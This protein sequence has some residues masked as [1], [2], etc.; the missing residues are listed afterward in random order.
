MIYPFSLSEV[1][2]GLGL[3]CVIVHALVLWKFDKCKGWCLRAHKNFRLGLVVFILAA[4][5]VV[6]LL[7]VMDLMEYSNLRI[8][9]IG[10]VVALAAL[11]VKHLPDYLAVRGL[12]LILVLLAKVLLD[13]AFLRDEPSKF[14]ITALAYLFA[15]AGM[16][17]LA[18]PY[19]FRDAMEWFWKNERRARVMTVVKLIF[20]GLLL[21]LGFFVY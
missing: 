14:V 16:V 10:I 13:A 15:V 19:W 17:W 6:W 20:G 12:G 18:V 21:Y 7:A 3:L 4:A 5:W 2:V 8:F 11:V 9:F 1:A